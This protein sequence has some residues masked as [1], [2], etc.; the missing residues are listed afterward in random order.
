M[1]VI[2]LLRYGLST[3]LAGI[4]PE[5]TLYEQFPFIYRL[6]IYALFFNGK[7][8]LPFMQSSK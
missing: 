2:I 7:M 3:Y 5:A 4:K 8:R 6:K 1:G